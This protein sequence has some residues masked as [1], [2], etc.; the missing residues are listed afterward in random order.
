MEK[1]TLTI[2][3]RVHRY[4]AVNCPEKHAPCNCAEL[5][6]LAVIG[7][8]TERLGLDVSHMSALTCETPEVVHSMVRVWKRLPNED[9]QLWYDIADGRI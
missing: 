2:L 1:N 3:G 7:I 8:C 4:I 6:R 9:R 5:K